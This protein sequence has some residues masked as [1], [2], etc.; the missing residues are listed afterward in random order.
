M[1]DSQGEWDQIKKKKKETQEECQKDANTVLVRQRE[2][3]N[4]RR[5][6]KEHK[7]TSGSLEVW[8]YAVKEKELAATRTSERRIHEM[9]KSGQEEEYDLWREDN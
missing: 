2:L 6:R 3:Q 4:G 1:D 7:W 8:R 9:E 5:R